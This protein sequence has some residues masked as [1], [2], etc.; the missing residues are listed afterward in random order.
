MI[1]GI[2]RVINFAHGSFYMLGAYVGYAVVAVFHNVWIALVLVPILVGGIGAFLEIT[3]LRFIYAK[4]HFGQFLLTFG[5]LLLIDAVVQSIWG[6]QLKEVPPPDLFSGS[7][8]ILGQRY[9]IYRIFLI[10]FSFAIATAVLIGLQ[11]T[12]TG[13]KIRAVAQDSEMAGA[14]GINVKLVRTLVFS[15]GCALAAMAGV[16][17]A[18][19][20]SA[21]L[22]M[23]VSLLIE[24]F[25]VV[26]IGG[27]GS[28]I[29]SLVGSLI[30]GAT[31][32][33]GTFLFPEGAMV[34]IYFLM[35]LILIVRTRGLFGEEE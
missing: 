25:V 27:L 16:A 15:L 1:F 23:G 10:G 32:T 9:P 24:S 30:V 34:F 17:I 14:I 21:S 12:K 8:M 4:S 19:M 2:M 20:V 28:V 35:A 33:W 11:K 3:T 29:G 26:I 22:G 7:L 6:T 31:Q 18:P 13:L 5:F